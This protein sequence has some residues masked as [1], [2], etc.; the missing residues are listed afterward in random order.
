MGSTEAAT[1]KFCGIAEGAPDRR[2]N[3]AHI[4]RD[5]LCAP[6]YYVLERVKREPEKL[7]QNDW[8]WFHDM[9]EFNM[10]NGMFVPVAQRREL[11]HLKPWTCKKC[12]SKHII[13]RD[14]NYTNYCTECASE[15]R[16]NREMPRYRKERSDKGGKHHR[17]TT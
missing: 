11:S 14:A 8:G 7:S 17:H 2:G 16:L 15:I 9:C 5:K 13:Y 1:C 10:R 12:G 4:N 3:A 6:C